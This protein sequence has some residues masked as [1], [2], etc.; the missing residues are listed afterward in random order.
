[1]GV[2]GSVID[3][4][5]RIDPELAGIGRLRRLHQLMLPLRRAGDEYDVITTVGCSEAFS[6]LR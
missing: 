2:F 4:S 5:L 3:W 1:V 6:A